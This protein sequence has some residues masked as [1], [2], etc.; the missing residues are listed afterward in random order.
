MTFDQPLLAA[1]PVAS[2]AISFLLARWLSSPIASGLSPMDLPNAR[3][4]HSTPVPR[5][6]GLA[7]LAGAVFPLLALAVFGTY[8]GLLAWIGAAL[9]LVA[10]IS[11]V[12]DRGHVRP[13][14]RLV[15]H[16]SSAVVLTVG[17]LYWSMLDLPG[18][19]V[20]IPAFAAG[21]LTILYIVWMT[22]LY[23]FMDGMDGLAGGMAVFGFAALA[24]LGWIGGEPLFTVATACVAAAAAGFLGVNFPPARIFLG[25]A[26]SSSLGFLAA[27]FSL[28]GAYLSLFPLWSAWLAFSPFIVDA[29]WTLA[30]R[31]LQRERIWEPHRS[32]HYQRLVLAGWSHRRTLVRSYFI[33]AA[34]A[35]S[36]VA[37]PRL[38]AHEQWLMLGA[39]AAVFTLVHFNVGLIERHSV[40][41]LVDEHPTADS[42]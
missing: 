4:L 16:V 23:N 24:L 42:T 30:T 10:T 40:A 1:L 41:L 19:T 26:G 17:G 29:T 31:A 5:T 11:F 34:A 33:M 8:S 39:W 13:L 7:V 28:W 27:A 36:A 20:T 18:F 12:D 37:A 21:A 9:L 32:H 14:V 15:I 35:A 22:N 38:P 2:L 6:G 3:S 25:D